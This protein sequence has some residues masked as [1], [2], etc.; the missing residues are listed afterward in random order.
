MKTISIPKYKNPFVVTINNNVYQYKGGD[1]VEVPDEVAEAIE[2]ALELVPKP[3][4]YLD[5][6]A[7]FLSGSIT[8]LKEEDLKDIAIISPYA[9]YNYD[10]LQSIKVPNNVASIGYSA[11]R[12]CPNLTKAEISKGVLSIKDRAFA[13]CES[14]S[15]IIFRGQT[16]PSI[17]IETF[18]SIPTTC[19][20]EVPSKSVEV[21][22]TAE[23]WSALASQIVAIKE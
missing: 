23:N 3:K 19:V 7:Q 14:L 12:Y 9:F 15:R 18:L 5:R 2:D 11:F 17:Q 10:K 4:R 21:Y 22:K 6:F 16:P 20:I 1:T 8:E 13:N